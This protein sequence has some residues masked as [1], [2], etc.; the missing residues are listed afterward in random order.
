MII[1]ILSSGFRGNHLEPIVRNSPEPVEVTESV[2]VIVWIRFRSDFIWICYRLLKRASDLH[3]VGQ[4]LLNAELFNVALFPTICPGGNQ[5]VQ[6]NPVWTP[7]ATWSFGAIHQKE[8]NKNSF[9]F[10]FSYDF[11]TSNPRPVRPERF[12]HS[13]SPDCRR[14][15]G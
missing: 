5:D 4:W 13:Y 14:E 15:S 7:I 1:E 2:C 8:F 11:V 9:S 12:G 10:D 3:I 6:A